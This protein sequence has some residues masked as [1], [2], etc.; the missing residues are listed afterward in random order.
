MKLLHIFSLGLVLAAAGASAQDTGEARPRTARFEAT[1]FLGY[2]AGGTFDIPRST[3]DS[4]IE[5]HIS[6][7]IALDYR[8]DDEAS[9]ELFYSR[10]PTRVSLGPQPG[11]AGLDVRYLLVGGTL[12][13]EETSRVRPYIIGLLGLA[14][15]SLDVADAADTTRFVMSLGVGLRVPVWQHV[16]IRLETR[17]YLTLVGSG[18][19]LFCRAGAAGEACRFQGN[20][21][22]LPQ[23][24]ALAGVAWS[25]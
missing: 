23:I 8:V 25:F 20:G 12:G 21:S 5:E 14:R 19:P 6:Y 10:Q 17:G 13:I 16:D 2:R 4:D 1:P 18:S 7:A 11:S 15:F 22:T 9:Y 24:E 3:E